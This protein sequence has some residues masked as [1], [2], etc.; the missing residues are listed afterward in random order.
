MQ[1]HL[2]ICETV[3]YILTVI[4][5]FSLFFVLKTKMQ[6]F[7][8][9]C[10]SG[11]LPFDGDDIPVTSCTLGLRCAVLKDCLGYTHVNVFFLG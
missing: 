2:F 10:D 1:L 9:S 8:H 4:V 7:L 5:I 11:Q 3:F 6:N